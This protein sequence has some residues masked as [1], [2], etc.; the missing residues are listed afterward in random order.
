MAVIEWIRGGR[1]LKVDFHKLIRNGCFPQ[2]RL[3]SEK[4]L[5]DGVLSYLIKI[6][7]GNQSAVTRMVLRNRNFSEHN[8]RHDP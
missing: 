5:S 2:K 4:I 7:E 6:S 3:A 8:S 1:S